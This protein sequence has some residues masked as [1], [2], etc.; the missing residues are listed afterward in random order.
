M[1]LVPSKLVYLFR[2][3]EFRKGT[4]QKTRW[5]EKTI[6]TSIFWPWSRKTSCCWMKNSDTLTCFCDIIPPL[7]STRLEKGHIFVWPSW[8]MIR[9]AMVGGRDAAR[10][11]HQYRQAF[12]KDHDEGQNFSK[13]KKKFDPERFFLQCTQVPWNHWQTPTCGIHS[14][15]SSTMVAVHWWWRTMPPCSF[16][17][18]LAR[19]G[20]SFF[21]RVGLG[22]A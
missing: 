21:S 22:K 13:R 15:T 19:W 4:R 10:M 14:E 9:Q 16:D 1:V 6:S 11:P 3:C 12:G 7:D 20:V 8:K 5:G 2:F 18:E 17:K